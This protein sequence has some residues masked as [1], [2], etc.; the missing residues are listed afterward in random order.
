MCIFKTLSNER[1]LCQSTCR[2]SNYNEKSKKGE[3]CWA[4]VCGGL[5]F[6]G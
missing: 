5:A 1:N 3:N 6:G 2:D 4:D